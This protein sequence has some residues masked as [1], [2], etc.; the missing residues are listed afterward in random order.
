MGALLH[1]CAGAFATL[2]LA[3]GVLTLYLSYKFRGQTLE[4]WTLPAIFIVLFVILCAAFNPNSKL[5]K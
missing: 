4:M 5:S 1:D 2:I 3:A